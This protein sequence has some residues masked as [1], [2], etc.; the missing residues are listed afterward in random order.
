M[1]ILKQE[2]MLSVEIN[3]A[4][5]KNVVKQTGITGKEGWD[6][7]SMRIFTLGKDGYTPRHAH[8]WPHIN[9]IIKGS[10]TL[11]I[12]GKEQAVKPGDTAYVPGGEEHQFQNA[13]DEDFSF[14]CI[15][16][17]EGDK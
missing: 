4:E 7:W 11:F 10:G 12:E 8:D 14:I 9:Y 1:P 6:G 16:P 15:V 5:A 17:E 13:G 3:M 2:D